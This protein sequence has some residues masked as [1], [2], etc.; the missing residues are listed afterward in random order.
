MRLAAE[1]RTFYV[2]DCVW[3][4]K[5]AHAKLQNVVFF[6]KYALAK[7]KN[8]S[9]SENTHM[10]MG[11]QTTKF[12]F[13]EKYALAKSQKRF[14]FGKYAHA[15]GPPNNEICVFFEKYAHATWRKAV[16]LEKYAHANLWNAIFLEKYA[17][18]AWQNAV[19]LEKYACGIGRNW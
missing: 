18:A 6:E 11:R 15:H 3:Q 16:F 12:V 17:H 7:S 8:A 4:L 19:F 13:F 1:I 9:H 14:L 2:P 5:Y 10:H